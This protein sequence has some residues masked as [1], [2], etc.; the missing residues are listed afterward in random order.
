MLRRWRVGRPCDD[1]APLLP[2]DDLR[3]LEQFETV[4]EWVLEPGDILY[5]PPRF[6]HDGVALG[7]DCMTYSIGFRAPARS[8][9][10]AAWCDDVLSGLDVD[11]RYAGPALP[12]QD[13][14]GEISPAAIDRLHA[15]VTE[16][17]L[18]RDAFARTVGRHATTPKYPDADWRPQVPF[19]IDDLRAMLGDGESLCRNPASRFSFVMSAPGLTLLFADG[20]CFECRDEAGALARSIC[21]ADRGQDR[22][23]IAPE[24]SEPALVL[25]CA[26]CNQGSLGFEDDD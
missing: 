13:N 14:P 17:L 18:D 2:H 21:A 19:A 7:D 10:I 9:L 12:V 16:S 24:L 20:E 6:A 4:D 15:M 22:V 25:L 3:L 26:L 1:A 23:D 8:E 11:D 5:L